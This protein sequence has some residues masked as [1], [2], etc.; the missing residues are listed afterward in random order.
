MN[1]TANSRL[2]PKSSSSDAGLS[3]AEIDHYRKQGYVVIPKLL[4]KL[5]LQEIDSCISSLMAEAFL[6]PNYGGVL[7]VEPKL[8]H[9][10]PI[11]RRIYDPFLRHKIFRDL[12]TQTNMCTKIEQ[13]IGPDFGIQ[14]SKLNMK[15]ALVGSA[16]EWHQDL[17][18]FPHT[19]HDL[20]TALIYLDDAD[21]KNGCLR[22]IPRQ[23]HRFFSHELGNG[24]F[25]GMITEDLTVAGCPAPQVLMA[26]AGSVIFMHCLTPH[27]SLANL[28]TTCRRSLIFEYRA[29]DAFPIY[30]G[31]HVVESESKAVHLQGTRARVA[32]FAGPAIPIPRLASTMRSLYDMQLDAE[33]AQKNPQQSV[34]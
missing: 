31:E 28:S 4:S 1:A 13:L 34:E 29:A 24:D 5:Q 2:R 12:A 8:V 32:R 17:A 15:P 7:E 22:V 33:A 9:G 16:V 21:E 23:H 18:Y 3:L 27:G 20:V 6:I 11:A 10:A 26:S 14:H 19:N 30:F 25:A